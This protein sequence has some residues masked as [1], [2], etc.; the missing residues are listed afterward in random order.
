[1]T[2]QRFDEDVIKSA[3]TVF[4]DAPSAVGAELLIPHWIS[5]TQ[6]HP[7]GASASPVANWSGCTAR[8]GGRG[9]L[10]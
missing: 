5:M 1:M 8:Q 4:A 9:D 3:A 6:L 10:R 2:A 7:E